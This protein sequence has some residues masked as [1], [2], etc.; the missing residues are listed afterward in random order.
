MIKFS[1]IMLVNDDIINTKLSI[2]RLIDFSVYQK[3]ELFIVV[4]SQLR[5]VKN[6]ITDIQKKDGIKVYKEFM[7]E[8]YGVRARNFV[9]PKCKGE[10]IVLVDNDTIIMPGYL[11]KFERYMDSN[12][13]GYVGCVGWTAKFENNVLDLGI[14]HRIRS[15]GFVDIVSSSLACYRKQDADDKFL[16]LP[17]DFGIYG[18][19]D[20]YYSLYMKTLGFR[21][22][23]SSWDNIGMHIGSK[24][25]RTKLEKKAKELNYNIVVRDLM[26]SDLRKKIKFEKVQG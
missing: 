4:N 10:F 5:Y 14:D 9:I 22:C 7:E 1:V 12:V 20:V 24:L 25:I 26:N 8:N 3:A 16:M 18:Y 19:D 21:G 15:G 17:D 13:I 2:N 6:Y 11:V 23:Y